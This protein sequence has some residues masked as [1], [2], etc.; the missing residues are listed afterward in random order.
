MQKFAEYMNAVDGTR[1][2][3]EVEPLFLEAFHPDATYVT[4]DGELDLTQWREM[5][6][7]LVDGGAVISDFEM[8]TADGVNA[9]YRLVLAAGDDAPL[10]LAATG[11]F[12]D[13]R[14]I[15]VEPTDPAA[16]SEMVAR[17]A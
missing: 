8:K 2:W 12:R 17:S 10:E 14:L 6:Q 5:A 9:V 7:G 3:E 4:A 1:S 16:Y 13:G 15:H 11:R